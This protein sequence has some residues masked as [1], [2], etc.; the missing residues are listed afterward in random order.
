MNMYDNHILHLLN[1]LY[2]VAQEWAWCG[3]SISSPHESQLLRLHRDCGHLHAHKTPSP[4]TRTIR[5]I[6][7]RWQN[8]SCFWNCLLLRCALHIFHKPQIDARGGNTSGNIHPGK[9]VPLG[10]SRGNDCRSQSW[11]CGRSSIT[12][13]IPIGVTG[14]TSANP[15]RPPAMGKQ[16]CEVKRIALRQGQT[17]CGFA[18]AYDIMSKPMEQAELWEH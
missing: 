12:D 4:P 13:K 5:T 2:S 7:G 6:H 16:S 18:V 9:T 11:L 14:V 10:G 8:R 15:S 1:L 17:A 3:M